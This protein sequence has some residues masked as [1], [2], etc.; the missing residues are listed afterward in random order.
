ML[1]FGCTRFNLNTPNTFILRG[2][3]FRKLNDKRVA[4]TLVE[5]IIA[6]LIFSLVSVG[7]YSFIRTAN[8][9]S[10][11]AYSRQDLVNQANSLLKL[12]QDDF[13]TTASAS[14]NI[15]E[16]GGEVKLQ[17]H[18][19]NKLATIVYNWQKP[20]LW[21]KVTY[22]NQTTLHVFSNN[23][24]SFSVEKKLRP[25]GPGGNKEIDNTPEQVV[26]RLGLTVPVP[27]SP[28]PLS[29]EQHAMATMR[30]VSSLKY[31]PHWR[32]VGN[33]Q[34]AFNAYGNLLKSIG[35]DANLLVEDVTKSIEKT[36]K[37]AEKAANDAL[38]QPKANLEAT[39][40]Q[41]NNAL[42]EIEKGKL[43]VDSAL[44]NLEENMKNLPED[45]FE[46]KFS[47]PSTWLA[48]KE[49]ALK[50]VQNTF[51]AMKTPDQM[52]FKKLE[53][54]ADPFHLD[55]SFADFV[56]SKKESVEQRMSMDTNKQKVTDLLSKIETKGLEGGRD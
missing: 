32:D 10:T 27:G 46:R 51:A 44:K 6:I 47:S 28:A 11:K 29:H 50:R 8:K 53:N 19:G 5:I 16:N 25:S 12:M 40:V 41:L 14:L 3:L 35:E 30:E 31:D 54:A 1:F 9:Q 17:Q 42:K 38:N 4:F 56:K 43:D 45:I 7:M 26:I 20:K 36:V 34:G 22:D 18:L 52:D 23:L 33:M 24:E 49:D 37:D 13:R 2:E 55:S 48:S 39:K 21:R 15:L